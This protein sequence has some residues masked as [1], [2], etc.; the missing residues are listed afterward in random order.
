MTQI[1]LEM[2]EVDEVILTVDR[3][4][5]EVHPDQTRLAVSVAVTR[6]VIPKVLELVEPVLAET[7]AELA[8]SRAANSHVRD[9]IRSITELARAQNRRL[10]RVFE[11]IDPDAVAFQ[12]LGHYQQQGHT[13][14]GRDRAFAKVTVRHTIS[15]LSRAIALSLATDEKALDNIRIE[16]LE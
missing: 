4:L 15:V 7:R 10:V 8:R 12:I 14:D 3:A 2:G 6:A 11:E 13:P 5:A 1:T 16:D 9:E